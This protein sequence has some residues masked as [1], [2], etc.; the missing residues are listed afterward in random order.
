[1]FDLEK[2]HKKILDAFDALSA[3]VQDL[4]GAPSDFQDKLDAA[5]ERLSRRVDAVHDHIENTIRASSRTFRNNHD[6]PEIRIKN[7]KHRLVTMEI[8]VAD[9]KSQLD[10]ALSTQN[11]ILN[12]G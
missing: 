7:S 2:E 8:D 12:V 6:H 10:T 5:H 11:K 9:S 4:A 1:M 3:L